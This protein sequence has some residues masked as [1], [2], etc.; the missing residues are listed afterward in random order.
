MNINR[1]LHLLLLVLVMSGCA[2]DNK[3]KIV[4]LVETWQGKEIRFPE[5][6]VY[7]LF[8]KDTVDYTVGVKPHRILVYTDSVGCTSCKV[9]LPKWKEWIA[10]VDSLSGGEVEFL[11]YFHPFNVKDI[12]Y[13]LKRDKFDL[14]VCIDLGDELNRLNEFPADIT[15]QTFLLDRENKVKVIGNP[16]HNTSV[17]NLYLKQILGEGYREAPVAE[18][19]AEA[20]VTRIDM[21]RFPMEKS[22]EAEFYIRNRGN[23]PLLILDT[24]SSCG[25]TTATYDKRP[26]AGGDSLR[27]VLTYTPKEPKYFQE[28]VT[29][30]CN[31]KQRVRLTVS[32]VVEEGTDK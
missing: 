13:L 16:I 25:C 3:Q 15:F 22:A 24:E 31:N 20:S 6:S 17:K 14:P 4:R 1:V 26:V 12:V 21:G 19:T 7:T 5:S 32:G 30:V 2:E 9:Q 10:E 27:V 28:S 18:T 11:F 23:E 8:G 29:L